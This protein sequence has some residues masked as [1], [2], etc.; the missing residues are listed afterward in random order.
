[1]SLA[2]SANILARYRV[3]DIRRID[4]RCD[5]Q[6]WEHVMLSRRAFASTV[7]GG[8]ATLP[9]K[10][11]V[12]QEFVDDPLPPLPADLQ[13]FS[14][15]DDYFDTVLEYEVLGTSQPTSHEI[16]VAKE[17]MAQAPF[18]CRP[19][20]VARYY[21]DIGLGVH[22]QELRPYARGWPVKYNPV[23]VEMFKVTSLNPLAPSGQGDATPWCAAFVN[24][25]IA[26]AMSQDGT[27]GDR[28][29]KFGTKSASSGSFRCWP[30]ADGMIAEPVEGCIVVWAQQGTV[31]GCAAGKGHVGFFERLSGNSSKPYVISGGNQTGDPLAGGTARKDGMVMKMMPLKYPA[32]ASFKVFHSCRTADF[33]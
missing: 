28:E 31:N 16:S 3:N 9:L 27:I 6:T 18:K 22:G 33:L 10:M 5:E 32:G 17:I 26:R 1:M 25:C 15:D 21:R 12:A 8:M 19:I 14:M 20:D 11:S 30:S 4:T 2:S 29:R 24:Y 23:I 7:V 13:G